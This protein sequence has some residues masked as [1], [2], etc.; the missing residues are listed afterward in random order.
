MPILVGTPRITATLHAVKGVHALNSKQFDQMT[1]W[2]NRRVTRRTG[3]F[4]AIGGAVTASTSDVADARR[5]EPAGCKTYNKKC[6]KKKKCCSG[7]KC[8]GGRCICKPDFPDVCDGYCVD[9][10]TDARACGNCGTMCAVGFACEASTCT[11]IC[12]FPEEYCYISANDGYCANL[13]TDEDNC[14]S[15]QN[16][17]PGSEVCTDG[18][19]CPAG[20]MCLRDTIVE[21]GGDVWAGTYGYSSGDE[22]FLYMLHSNAGS[23]SLPCYSVSSSGQASVTISTTTGLPY[24]LGVTYGNGRIYVTSNSP[25]YEAVWQYLIESN[26]ALTFVRK[27]GLVMASGPA[28]AAGEFSLPWAI[29]FDPTSSTLYV[30]DASPNN[31]FAAITGY[32]IAPDGTVGSPFVYGNGLISDVA[33]GGLQQPRGLGVFEGFLF[34]STAASQIARLTINSSTGAL[35]DPTEVASSGSSSSQVSDPRGI[36]SDETNGVLYVADKGNNRV[37]GF[38][39]S[40]AGALTPLI[41]VTSAGS[42]TLTQANTAVVA[43]TSLVVGINSSTAYVLG[44]LAVP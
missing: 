38:A 2:F 8:K 15:C 32:P 1:R 27:F 29:A 16:T 9:F 36:G 11:A 17:C 14:G 20:E 25:G 33:A 6:S 40:E 42:T 5:A 37:L 39:V 41:T 23:G 10:E 22:W 3:I 4:A 31:S 18:R 26:G 35:S 19:C 21:G 12:T 28:T 7:M 34:V 43:G 44:P 24:P 30:S 13:Q